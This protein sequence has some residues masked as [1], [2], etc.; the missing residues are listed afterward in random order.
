MPK[1]W[2]RRPGGKSMS[3][4]LAS[5]ESEKSIAEL[6]L[7]SRAGGGDEN[8][9]IAGNRADHL[10]PLGGVDGDGHALRRTD[11]GFQHGEIRAGGKPALTNCLS[12]EKS[13]LG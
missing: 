13:L 6:A 12:A 5:E 2:A 10:G 9:V 4:I 1:E 8:C 3:W 7:V 11:G